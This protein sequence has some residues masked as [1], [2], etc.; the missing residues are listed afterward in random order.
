M[1]FVTWN[2]EAVVVWMCGVVTSWALIA[3]GCLAKPLLS[4]CSDFYLLFCDCADY[5]SDVTD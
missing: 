1:C 4:S 3:V 5:W 2:C